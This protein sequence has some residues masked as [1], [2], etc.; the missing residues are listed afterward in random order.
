VE[1]EEQEIGP[2]L[3]KYKAIQNN[4]QQLFSEMATRLR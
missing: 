2:I 3:E 1:R 4:A